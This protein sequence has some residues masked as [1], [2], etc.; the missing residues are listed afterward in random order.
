ML[1]FEALEQTLRL[2]LVSGHVDKKKIISWNS[3]HPYRTSIPQSFGA[4][5]T[6]KL[7]HRFNCGTA[8]PGHYLSTGTTDIHG[9]IQ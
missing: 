5:A 6:K 3:I 4:L 7:D 1:H 8:V 9:G 2:R